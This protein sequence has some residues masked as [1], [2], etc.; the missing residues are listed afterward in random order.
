MFFPSLR[1]Q[2]PPEARRQADRHAAEHSVPLAPRLRIFLSPIARPTE[3]GAAGRHPVPQ[4][5]VRF[6]QAGDDTGKKFYHLKAF[7]RV[8]RVKRPSGECPVMPFHPLAGKIR[9]AARG[10]AVARPAPQAAHE[11]GE[12]PAKDS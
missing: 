11:V 7:R 8:A 10:R 2:L 12:S 5:S 1:W 6:G 4:R 3:E 9:Q